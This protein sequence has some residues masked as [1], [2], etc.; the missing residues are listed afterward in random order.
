MVPR[1]VSHTP[2]AIE[3]VVIVWLSD[4]LSGTACG[5]VRCEIGTIGFVT[6]RVC[7][8]VALIRIWI[9][10]TEVVPHVCVV[11]Y[12]FAALACWLSSFSRS[13]STSLY[14]QSMTYVIANR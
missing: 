2:D 8:A 7:S 12:L 11:R 1:A 3:S 9:L 14:G 10:M 13:G 4:R 5:V 6:L